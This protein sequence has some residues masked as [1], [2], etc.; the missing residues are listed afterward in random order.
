MRIV[1]VNVNSHVGSTGKISYGLYKFLKQNGNEVKLCCRGIGEFSLDDESV[2]ELCSKCEFYYSSFASWLTGYEGIYNYFSTSK[3]LKIIQEFEPDVV[4]LF[5]LT[6]HYI[7]I[8]SLLNFLKTNKIRTVYSMMDDYPFVGKCSFI[9]DCNKFMCECSK[10]PNLGE[11]PPSLIFDFSKEIFNR[12][13]LIYKDFNELTITGVKWSC[14]MAKKS[15]LTKNTSIAHID[16]PINYKEYFYP[17]DAKGLKEKL[18]IPYSNIVFLTAISAKAVRKGGIYFLQLA[19][20]MI[21]RTDITFVFVGYDRDDWEI[22]SNMITIG[23]VS[24]QSELATYYSMADIYICT[25]LADTFPTTCLNALGC[26][27]PLV[28]FDAGGVSYTAEDPYGKFV[29]V[30]D[31]DAMEKICRTVKPKTDAS[32]AET[33]QYAVERYS[34]EIIFDKFLG[35][36]NRNY[37]EFD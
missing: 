19:K 29:P 34:E 35:V 20:Q 4:H 2:I 7:N 1:I 24:S 18:G 3:L 21:Y 16:H 14:M 33:R 9:R 37:S 8:F 12:K 26:G 23:Y 15:A 25:S 22:P 10:C 17:R 6:G 28:G 31:V 11:Y 5:N 27:T 13:K 30:K 36:Y 32:I